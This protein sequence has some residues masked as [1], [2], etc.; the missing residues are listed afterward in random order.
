MSATTPAAA[1]TAAA[2]LMQQPLAAQAGE[3][4][5]DL[6]QG[7]AAIGVHGLSAHER[8]GRNNYNAGLYARWAGPQAGVLDG[9]Q[10]G[11]YHNSHRTW[12]AYAARHVA[13]VDLANGRVHASVMA[14]AVVGYPMAPVLPMVTAN[15]GLRLGRQATVTLSA[16]PKPRA[17][18][19]AVIHL[20]AEWRLQ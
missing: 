18:G 4:T 2:L 13:G 6:A 14:G 9:V 1:L 15:L 7:L 11:A 8:P 20:S 12:S 3:I 19:V 17:D 10:I 16:M 5:G